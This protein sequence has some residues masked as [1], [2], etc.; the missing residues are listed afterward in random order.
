VRGASGNAIT[1]RALEQSVLSGSGN[2]KNCS[3]SRLN[4]YHKALQSHTVA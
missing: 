3:N 2:Y 4:W 1:V